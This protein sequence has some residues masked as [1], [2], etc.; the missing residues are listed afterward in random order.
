MLTKKELEQLAG[1]KRK[2]SRRK[3]ASSSL[4]AEAIIRQMIPERDSRRQKFLDSKYMIAAL[5]VIIA[6][7][8]NS[9][10]S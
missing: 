1:G 8:P 5:T 4:N 7:D 10:V 3:K 9:T 6:D 2:R